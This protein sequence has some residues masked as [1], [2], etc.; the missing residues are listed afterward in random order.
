MTTTAQ[1]VLRQAVETLADDASVRWKVAELCRYFNAGQNAVRELD[2]TATGVTEP[3]ALAAGA[4][5]LLPAAAAQLIEVIGNTTGP[6]VRQTGRRAMDAQLP[7][8]QRMAGTLE[9]KQWMF[10]E[11]DETAFYVFPPALLGASLDVTYSAYPA[12]ISE[13]YA[14]SATV[15]TVT[16]NMDLPDKYANALREYVLY[17]AYAKDGEHPANAGRSDRHYA[18]FAAALGGSAAAEASSKPRKTN[19]EEAARANP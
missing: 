17:R 4:R 10:D 6:A 18:A 9:V 15:L 11:R 16:G 5:Q 7:G 2:P 19:A 13:A 12:P 1:S 3:L 8:W 14:D